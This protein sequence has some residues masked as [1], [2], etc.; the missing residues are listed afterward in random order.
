V[1]KL[2][3]RLFFM[4]DESKVTL[5]ELGDI[6]PLLRIIVVMLWA[7]AE[8]TYRII[9]RK[10]RAKN[11]VYDRNRVNQAIRQLREFDY[12]IVAQPER[13]GQ[14]PRLH[15]NPYYFKFKTSPHRRLAL[16]YPEEVF[17]VV[18]PSKA[19][20]FDPND[21]LEGSLHEPRYR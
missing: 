4:D 15:I 12:L 14:M 13:R 1:I 19:P 10:A 11:P 7:K 6:D 21:I 3:R 18:I 2:P 17:A 16:W 8:F 5:D 20:Q 9:Q